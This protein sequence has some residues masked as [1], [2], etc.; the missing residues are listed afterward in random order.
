MRQNIH[1]CS[2]NFVVNYSFRVRVGLGAMA[3]KV[4]SIIP[5]DPEL[6]PHCPMQVSIIPRTSF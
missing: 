2:N 1:E 6:E 3:M 5:N 4:Y